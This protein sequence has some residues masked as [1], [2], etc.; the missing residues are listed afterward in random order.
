MQT[1]LIL[2]E[3]EEGLQTDDTDRG[4]GGIT[5]RSD[6]DRGRGGLQ[7]DLILIEGE[8]GLQIDLIL[9]D[10][11]EGLQTY[12]PDRRR[13]GITDRSDTDRGIGD[14]RRI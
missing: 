6:T 11:E 3:G 9:T 5:E 14:Y 7:T 4:R 8:E 2:I 12:D 1:D 13:G 10:R